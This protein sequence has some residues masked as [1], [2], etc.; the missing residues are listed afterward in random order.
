MFIHSSQQLCILC[1]SQQCL[2]P[3]YPSQF[4]FSQSFTQ[5]H[6][7]GYL[8]LACVPLAFN[9]PFN[10]PSFL[11]YPK[12]F[13]CIFMIL[14]KTSFLFMCCV[15]LR[16][17]QSW[18]STSLLSLDALNEFRPSVTSRDN[19]LSSTSLSLVFPYLSIPLFDL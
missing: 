8:L 1:S 14:T 10:K 19:V 13:N 12:N 3:Y 18:L 16:H 15:H 2:S 9:M 7:V 5:A 4:L 11:M 17:W 6:Y